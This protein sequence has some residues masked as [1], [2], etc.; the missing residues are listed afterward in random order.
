MEK[1]AIFV[2]AGYLLSCG[3]ELCTGTPGAKRSWAICS[4]GPLVLALV[5]ELRAKSKQELLRV[6]WY[7]GAYNQVHT[8]EHLA[9]ANLPDVKVRLG[10]IA[11]GEQKGVDTLIVLDLTTLARERAISTAYLVTGDEDIRE[12][13]IQA[14]QMGVRVSLV[15]LNPLNA[16]QPNQA[17]T[18][19]READE[20][21][22]LSTGS[23]VTPFFTPARQLTLP[24]IA[25]AA[26]PPQPATAAGPVP[27]PSAAAPAAGTAAQPGSSQP[28]AAAPSPYQ[29]GGDFAKT[30]LAGNP[31]TADRAAMSAA[32][33]QRPRMIP[34]TIDSQL[35]RYATTT[36]G[37]SPLSEQ[38]KRE[39]R[40]GFWDAL[41]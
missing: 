14:Q 23:F 25:S 34:Q 19:I 6:Y 33:L 21:I 39:T 20:H 30:W 27:P 22:V 13:V 12:G 16:Q 8:N 37:T 4:Y 7:D 35:L 29:I 3:S 40:R 11:H 28:A 24:T 32:K 2:D 10:R 9:I 18:M 5:K 17:G 41:P 15:G 1:F 31:P 38:Q 36:L 26:A